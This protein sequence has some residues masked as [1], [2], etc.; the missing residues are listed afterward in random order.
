MRTD[1]TPSR[2]SLAFIRLIGRGCIVIVSFNSHTLPCWLRASWKR[3]WCFVRGTNTRRLPYEAK[4][5]FYPNAGAGSTELQLIG[6]S[7]DLATYESWPW[8][9]VFEKQNVTDVPGMKEVDAK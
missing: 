9:F 2:L 8:V 3:G 6:S 7:A 5:L 1:K 4:E